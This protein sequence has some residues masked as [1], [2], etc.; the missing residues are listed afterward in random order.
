M[1]AGIASAGTETVAV[2]DIRQHVNPLLD[3]KDD[4]GGVVTAG[5]LS[6]TTQAITDLEGTSG[7]VTTLG[8]KVDS[9]T[10]RSTPMTEDR[11]GTL[12]ELSASERLTTDQTPSSIAQNVLDKASDLKSNI[13]T[14]ATDSGNVADSLDKAIHGDDGY[15]ESYNQKLAALTTAT[16]NLQQSL[17]SAPDSLKN[18][19]DGFTTDLNTYVD[20]IKEVAVLEQERRGLI[21]KIATGK[22]EVNKQLTD[23]YLGR[24]IFD[25]KY[26]NG[27][28]SDWWY[29]HL[30]EVRNDGTVR[31]YDTYITKNGDYGN[32]GYTVVSKKMFFPWPW[33]TWRRSIHITRCCRKVVLMG[34]LVL[35]A[36]NPAITRE[37]DGDLGLILEVTLI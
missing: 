6:K 7:T 35:F 10:D 24:V 5:D 30:L 19:L 4:A 31:D 13:D 12:G 11:A 17:I 1:K 25:F 27:G 15:A 22:A 16:S 3:Q 2:T 37:E 33:R 26:K 23:N 20:K 32:T 14:L 28:A 9:W 8:T 18:A 21:E 29:G 36:R 34:V